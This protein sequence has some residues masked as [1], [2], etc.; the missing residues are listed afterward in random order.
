MRMTEPYTRRV[1]GS[2]YRAKD[3]GTVGRY[4]RV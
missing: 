2:I 1:I 3:Q 4:G